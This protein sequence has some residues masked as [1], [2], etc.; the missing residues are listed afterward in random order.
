[1]LFDHIEKLMWF[2]NCIWSDHIFTTFMVCLVGKYRTRHQLHRVHSTSFDNFTL[3]SFG[4]RPRK[5]IILGN[6]SDLSNATDIK[7]WTTDYHENILKITS[8]P[9][10]W[11]IHF[12]KARTMSNHRSLINV[13]NISRQFD[14]SNLS[15]IRTR[16]KM[17]LHWVASSMV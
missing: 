13:Y 9:F 7:L 8:H 16:C 10:I 14:D 11:N 15:G 3:L 1:M 5:H 6:T 17:M 4:V 2:E 12:V